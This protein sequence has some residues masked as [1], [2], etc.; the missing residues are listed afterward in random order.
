MSNVV[1]LFLHCMAAPRL[2]YTLLCLFQHCQAFASDA[3]T[4]R[5]HQWA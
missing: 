2:V 5:L 1:S 3:G 4:G